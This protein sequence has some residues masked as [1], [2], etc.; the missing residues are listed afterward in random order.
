MVRV[1]G[2]ACAGL[3]ALCLV[4]AAFG[5]R[6]G[7]TA[8]FEGRCEFSGALRQDPPLTNTTAPGSA[9]ARARGACFGT[10][11]KHDGDVRTLDGD[12]VDYAAQAEGELS[13]GGGSSSGAGEL[14]F[15]GERI[16]FGFS[17]VRG[18]GAAAISLAG[19][20]GGEASA[21]ATVSP[22]E[23]PVEIA[24]RCAGEGLRTVRIDISLT[25][26][27]ISG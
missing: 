17:E 11:T 25:S 20:G 24:Q 3:V 27:G 23:D 1:I 2:P 14:R 6:A 16:R 21:V 12:R 26:P 4:P 13:C 5:H 9:T 18:P 7:A 10:L 8:T 15:P 19:Q 22:E